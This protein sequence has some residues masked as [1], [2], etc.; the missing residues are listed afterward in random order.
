[1]KTSHIALGAVGAACLIS[2]AIASAHDATV[3]CDTATGIYRVTPTNLDLNPRWEFG[4]SIV[5]V[6]WSDGFHVVKRL[7][8][9][10]VAPTPVPPPV[11][12]VPEPQPQLPSLPP[13][14]APP[15]VFVPE[16]TG[17]VAPDQPPVVKTVPKK[18]LTCARFKKSHP[19]LGWQAYAKLGLVYSD[20]HVNR[21]KPR[22][23]IPAVA[24]EFKRRATSGGGTIIS[25]GQPVVRGVFVYGGGQVIKSGPRSGGV[26][27][28][29]NLYRSPTRNGT[30][31]LVTTSRYNIRQN[32][33]Q[34][35]VSTTSACI[36]SR[37]KFW[38][39]TTMQAASKSNRVAPTVQLKAKSFSVGIRCGV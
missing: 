28:N 35:V 13:Q 8:T 10:C 36:P 22:P 23:V 2:P 31:T 5:T 16:V 33:P 39:F 12:P 18:K 19:R 17:P 37:Q 32:V 3:V 4:A 21:R 11:P 7:P 14:P 20:C 1:M 15:A 25:V 29:I 26:G 30:G 6:T 34:A 24:G 27:V 9:P 38:W